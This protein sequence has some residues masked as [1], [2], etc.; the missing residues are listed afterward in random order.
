M[1]V[2]L[3][4]NPCGTHVNDCCCLVWEG[5][6]S[7]NMRGIPHIIASQ[8]IAA[9]CWAIS[10]SWYVLESSC[11]PGNMSMESGS[12]VLWLLGKEYM[13]TSLSCTLWK[14]AAGFKE[15]LVP[16]LGESVLP[17]MKGTLGVSS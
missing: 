8:V 14:K 3:C 1:Q 11:A 16:T 6:S 9:V 4:E 2:H 17:T 15:T 13:K 7:Y 10:L 5:G 12:C